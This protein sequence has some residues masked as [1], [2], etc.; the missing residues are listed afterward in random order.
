MTS[1][2]VT[3]GVAMG[4]DAVEIVVLGAVHKRT[5]TSSNRPHCKEILADYKDKSICTVI[6]S[7]Y[8]EPCGCRRVA[9][10]LEVVDRMF[11]IIAPSAAVD[12]SVRAKTAVSR[13]PSMLRRGTAHSVAAVAPGAGNRRRR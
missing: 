2:A 9:S 11:I 6:H 5:Q 3:I 4:V 10:L 8:R 1:A 7:P 13:I 12:A